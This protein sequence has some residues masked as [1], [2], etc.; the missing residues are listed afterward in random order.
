MPTMHGRTGGGPSAG[1]VCCT[2]SGVIASRAYHHE[3]VHTL[4]SRF[5]PYPQVRAFGEQR[6]QRRFS[7]RRKTKGGRQ[8]KLDPRF[9][10]Y[11][12]PLGIDPIWSADDIGRGSI[13]VA[14]RVANEL[15]D[16]HAPP[17]EVGAWKRLGSPWRDWRIRVSLQNNRAPFLLILVPAN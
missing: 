3:F 10:P 5:Q 15:A 11:V 8:R 7:R 12:V 6:A 9:G 17:Y 1:D 16:G 14:V 4:S 2:R 13:A